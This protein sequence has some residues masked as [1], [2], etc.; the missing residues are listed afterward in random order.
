MP[1]KKILLLTAILFTASVFLVSCSSKDK[2]KTTIE[3]KDIKR[4]TDTEPPPPPP[5]VKDETSNAVQKC[6]ENDGLKY[7]VKI[8][9]TI[10]G[11]EVKGQLASTETGSNQTE[12]K[13]F[14][15]TVEG[16][17]LKVKF[18]GTPPVIGDASE[19]TDKPWMLAKTKKGNAEI[20]LIIFNAKNY[21]T[22]KWEDQK[23]EFAACSK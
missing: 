8:N 19:W 2:T 22:N 13:E 1:I 12:T 4:E 7:A 6:F 20:L 14:S 16:D 17:N 15:G 23:F 10:A 3:L 9:M 21:Q 11:N 18:E 5:P